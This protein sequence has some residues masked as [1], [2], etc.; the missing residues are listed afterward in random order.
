MSHFV[1]SLDR[2]G[3][4]IALWAAAKQ[5]VRPLAVQILKTVQCQ[6][7]ARK[8]TPVSN[9]RLGLLQLLR[10]FEDLLAHLHAFWDCLRRDLDCVHDVRS[11]SIYSSQKVFPRVDS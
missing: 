11:G 9:D 3:T 7:L 2:L 6:G 10:P 5:P 4:L 1:P 8:R